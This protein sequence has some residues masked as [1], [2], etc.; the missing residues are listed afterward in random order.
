MALYIKVSKIF[1]LKNETTAE[2]KGSKNKYALKFESINAQ[3]PLVIFEANVNLMMHNR[4]WKI[5]HKK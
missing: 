4:Q 5:S 2:Q 1:L 3:I